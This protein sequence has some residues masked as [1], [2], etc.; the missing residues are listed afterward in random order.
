MEC[1]TKLFAVEMSSYTDRMQSDTKGYSSN[2]EHHFSKYIFY[3]LIYGMTQRDGTG[4]EEGGGF[5]MGNMCTPV[6]DSC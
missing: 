2:L 6:A 4:R 5:R 1:L 3:F